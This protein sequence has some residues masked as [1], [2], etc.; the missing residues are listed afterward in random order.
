MN[1]PQDFYKRHPELK[2]RKV[3]PLG[4]ALHDIYDKVVGWCLLRAATG[5][6]HVIDGSTAYSSVYETRGLAS[7]LYA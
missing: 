1:W 3:R 7:Y 6:G 5:I 4:W 2:A